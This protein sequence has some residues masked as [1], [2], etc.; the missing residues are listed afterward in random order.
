[1]KNVLRHIRSWLQ[2]LIVP[3]IDSKNYTLR[4]DPRMDQWLHKSTEYV[5]WGITTTSQPEPSTLPWYAKRTEKSRGTT[6]TTVGWAKSYRTFSDDIHIYEVWDGAGGGRSS[7]TS[8]TSNSRLEEKYRPGVIIGGVPATDVKVTGSTVTCTAPPPKVT[9]LLASKEVT[10]YLERQMLEYAN[11]RLDN[12]LLMG[13]PP[14]ITKQQFDFDV[15]NLK[16]INENIPPGKLELVVPES[17]N[18]WCKRK[19]PTY[20]SCRSKPYIELWVEWK[21]DTDPDLKHL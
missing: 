18:S 10:A 19:Y 2:N 7:L 5:K 14:P 3:S 15:K 6:G 17:F 12:I 9:S 20:K 1:M 4:V 21:L 13:N 16:H 8:P 11:Q